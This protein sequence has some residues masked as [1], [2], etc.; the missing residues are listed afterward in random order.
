MKP[1]TASFLESAEQ[2]ISHAARILAIDIP[3]QAARLAY[4]AQFHAAQAL[5]FERTDKIAKTHRGV[6]SQFHRI[7]RTE[8][9]LPPELAGQLSAAYRFKA[10]VDYEA[11]T[12]AAITAADAAEAIATA[13]RFVAAIRQALTEPV[14]P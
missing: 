6:D 11:G 9:N 5:L 14:A 2:A 1:E 13:E 12:A 7:A 10:A 8:P 3:G 4:Y